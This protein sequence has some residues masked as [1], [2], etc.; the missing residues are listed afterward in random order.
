M[1]LPLRRWTMLR[2]T[3]FEVRNTALEIG[4]DQMVPPVLGYLADGRQALDASVVDQYVDLPELL[5]RVG[6]HCLDLDG[7]ADIADGR[8]AA[9]AKRLDLRRG[10]LRRFDV[11]EGVG[12]AGERFADVGDHDIRARRAEGER[13]RSQLP[14]SAAGDDDR[15]VAEVVADVAHVLVSWSLSGPDH[16]QTAGA[17][18]SCVCRKSSTRRQ[19]SAEASAYCSCERS[20]KE[21]GASG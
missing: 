21:C 15:F 3:A 18:A 11:C 16:A 4:V 6:D 1:I 14:P 10:R 8:P 12:D 20:K 13:M 19:A 9:N 17:F 5:D 2:D 7:V